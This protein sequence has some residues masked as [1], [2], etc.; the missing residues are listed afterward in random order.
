MQFCL[1]LQHCFLCQILILQSQCFYCSS[2]PSELGTSSDRQLFIDVMKCRSGH[3]INNCD[4]R[5]YRVLKDFRNKKNIVILKPD[6]GN[7]V[8]VLDRT[9]YDSGICKIINDHH[10]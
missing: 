3:R 2:N 9:A 7:G 6:K 4:L 1:R 5:K 8:V 10:V